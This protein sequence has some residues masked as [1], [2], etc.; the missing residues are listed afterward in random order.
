M[1]GRSFVPSAEHARMMV[2]CDFSFPVVRTFIILSPFSFTVKPRGISNVRGTSSMFIM[3]SRVTL[4]LWI[5]SFTKFLSLF[6]QNWQEVSDTLLYVPSCSVDFFPWNG[7]TMTGHPEN[8]ASPIPSSSS[9]LSVELEEFTILVLQ[10][11]VLKST[12]GVFVWKKVKDSLHV[13]KR[14]KKANYRHKARWPILTHQLL[15][16]AKFSLRCSVAMFLCKIY[17]L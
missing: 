14:L 8:P 17:Y 7:S 3:W 12:C 1:S 16:Y 9:G 15:T 6:P 10:L 11:F 5:S 13:T 2:K 4:C